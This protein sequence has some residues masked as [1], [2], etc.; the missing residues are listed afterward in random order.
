MSNHLSGSL[1][2][3]HV[4]CNVAFCHLRWVSTLNGVIIFILFLPGIFVEH[5]SPGDATDPDPQPHNAQN[6]L[7]EQV[8][9]ERRRSHVVPIV[10]K[11]VLM[12]REHGKEA[13]NPKQLM[14][15]FST[16]SVIDGK[17]Y[18]VDKKTDEEKKRK[19]ME[20][21]SPAPKPDKLA[22][23]I[24]VWCFFSFFVTFVLMET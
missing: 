9:K 10:P 24:S 21:P 18:A 2:L 22:C 17:N 5:D 1:R 16:I 13:R 12:L 6:G 11:E 3:R 20:S 19:Q 23:S 8:G 15:Q 4:A 14:K 7:E